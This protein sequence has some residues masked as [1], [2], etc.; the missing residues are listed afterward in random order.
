MN[1]NKIERKRLFVIWMKLQ[2]P[3]KN[4]NTS[5][6]DVVW[7]HQT[8]C[9]LESCPPINSQWLQLQWNELD[10][11]VYNSKQHT[12]HKQ[13]HHNQAELF[14]LPTRYRLRS[15]ANPCD[16]YLTNEGV[17][18]RSLHYLVA[19]GLSYHV[20]LHFNFNCYAE[21]YVIDEPHYSNN[22]GGHVF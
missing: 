6:S 5:K 10:Q 8:S 21:H 13:L 22:C 1:E 20:C 19:L 7:S 4:C 2:K 11:P 9:R 3:I 12:L 18:A 17:R 15:V 14:P 16:L